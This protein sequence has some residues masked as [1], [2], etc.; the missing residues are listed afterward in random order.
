MT[1]ATAVPHSDALLAGEGGTPELTNPA[2]RIAITHAERTGGL[3]LLFGELRITLHRGYDLSG[4]VQ[5]YREDARR[6]GLH[7][8][9]GES[10][11]AAFDEGPGWA[12]ASEKVAVGESWG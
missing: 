12:A 1:T 7:L 10:D 11:F 2:E 9:S 4:A 6:L 3:T 8:D 5:L